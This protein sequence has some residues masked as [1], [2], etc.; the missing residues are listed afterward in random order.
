M[1]SVR[2]QLH[3]ED[4]RAI[5]TVFKICLATLKFGGGTFLKVPSSFTR[6]KPAGSPLGESHFKHGF[7]HSQE[8]LVTEEG[9]EG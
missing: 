6:V 3:L 4:E 5:E 9:C 2:Q 8:E 1:R 7:S